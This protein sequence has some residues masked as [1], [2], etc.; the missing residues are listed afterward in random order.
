M[1]HLLAPLAATAALAA[2]PA[3]A[4]HPLGGMR[5][6][7]FA[8]G[9]MSGVGHPIIG[10]D[11]LFF[12]LAVGVA[13]AVAGRVATAP[14]AYIGTMLLGVA[15]ASAGVRV[16]F[17]EA[18]IALS[19][20]VLGGLLVSGRGVTPMLAMGLFAG[21]GLFH[22]YAFGGAIAGQESVGAAVFAGY[23]VGLGV[24]QYVI[25][26]GAGLVAALAWHAAGRATTN[27]RLAGGVVAGVGAFLVLEQL[28]GAAFAAL[29]L[30]G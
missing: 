7:T 18:V 10:F 2:T 11:H 23:L 30:A 5:M 9:L 1:R 19:L 21:L 15:V 17:A 13:A 24:T 25:A 14:L 28:E 22:G 29:G 6:T 12:V 26:L 20:L 27:A 3:L 4:H 8:H 16:P